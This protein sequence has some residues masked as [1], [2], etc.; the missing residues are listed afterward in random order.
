MFDINNKKKYKELI[1]LIFFHVFPDFTQM[2]R[3]KQETPVREV[4][5]HNIKIWC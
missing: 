3:C 5:E 1:I 4:N 2:A